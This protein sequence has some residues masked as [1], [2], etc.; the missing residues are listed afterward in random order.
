MTKKDWDQREF[1]SEGSRNDDA[2]YA[3]VGRALSSWEVIEFW[4]SRLFGLFVSA[5]RE[6]PAIRGYGAVHGFEAR[7][8]M[9]KAA[10]E[11]YFHVAAQT[12]FGCHLDFAPLKA[13]FKAL[14]SLAKNYSPRR[15]E[16]AHGVVKYTPPEFVQNRKILVN[17]YPELS[18]KVSEIAYWALYPNDASTDRV[19][20]H[21]NP[22]YIYSFVEILYYKNQFDMVRAAV[23]Q[24]YHKIWELKNEINKADEATRSVIQ[25]GNVTAPATDAGEI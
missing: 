13:E 8:T 18:I 10:G 4:L 20:L 19:D 2:I 15:N 9:V 11:A 7:L 16:I 23:G 3:A 6:E 14:R 21:Y 25:D 24:F 17:R 22:A 5:G 12:K 1:P